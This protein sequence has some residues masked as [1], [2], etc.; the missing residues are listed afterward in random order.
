MIA[1]RRVSSGMTERPIRGRMRYPPA[2]SGPYDVALDVSI[3]V[4]VGPGCG[5]NSGTLKS[6]RARARLQQR[7]R[8][9]RSSDR[10]VGLETLQVRGPEREPLTV[11]LG[12]VL[13][14]QRR[15][16][17][18]SGRLRKLHRVRRHGARAPAWM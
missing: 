4:R 18:L 15:R 6:T 2:R 8:R 9:C 1:S 3:G 17:H 11:N 12:V 16:P 13:A 7:A 5:W 14:Q 10:L